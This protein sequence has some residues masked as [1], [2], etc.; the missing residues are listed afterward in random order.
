VLTALEFELTVVPPGVSLMDDERFTSSAVS[1][2]GFLEL[3]L[4]SEGLDQSQFSP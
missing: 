4:K 1:I 3:S 2:V